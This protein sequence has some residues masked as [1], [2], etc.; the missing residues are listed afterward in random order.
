MSAN[1]RLDRLAKYLGAVLHGR[2]EVENLSDFKRFI[3]AI[4]KQQN[5][6]V[7][8][9]RLVTSPSALSA[10]HN[11]LRFNLTPAFINDYTSKFIKF[12]NNPDVKPLCNGLFLQQLLLVMLEPRSLWNA[13]VYAFHARTLDEDAIQTFCWLVTELLSLPASY[14]VDITGDVQTIVNDDLIVSSP[15]ASLR[16]LGH[17]MKYLLEMKSSASAVLSSEHTAGGRHDNDFSDFR[18]IAI[19]PTADE[20]GCTETPF[21]R[22]VDEISQLSGN[23]RIAA[24][25]DNQFRLLREDMLSG[26]RDDIQVARGTKKG[27]RSALRLQGLSLARISCASADLRYL[28]PC[29]VGVTAKS[30]LNRLE[31]LSKEDKKTYLKQN[32]DFIRHHAFGCFLRDTEIVAFATIERS[33]DDL[34][35]TPPIVMLR[36]AEEEALKKCILFLKIY[37]DVEFL[38]VD[39]PIFA[40][41][42]I[43]KCLQERTDFPLTEELFLYEKDKPVK[44]SSLAPWAVIQELKEKYRRNIEHILQTSRPITLDPSQL[45]SLLKGL[46]QR[47]SLIQGPPGTGKSFIGA[48]LAKVLHDHT[49]DKILVMCYTNHALDQFL[50][51]LLDIGIDASHMV[52]LGSKSTPRTQ[53]LS[54]KEQKITWNRPQTAWNTINLLRSEGDELRNSLNESFTTYQTVVTNPSAI[55]EYLEFEEPAYFEAFTVPD[56][57]D[58]MDVVGKHGNVVNKNYLYQRWV[59][60]QSPEPFNNMLPAQCRSIWEAEKRFRDEKV[61]SWKRALLTEQ[62]ASLAVQIKLFDKCQEKLSGVLG[63]RTREILKR[64]QIIGCTT[65]ASAMY[66][67]DIRNASPGIVLLEEA[68]EILESHVL[69]AISPQTKHLVMI[70]DHLQLRPKVNSYALSLEKGDGYDLNVSLFER[71]IHEGYPHTTLLKQHRMCPEISSLVRSLTYPGLEDDDKT[72]NRPDPR[73]LCD[74]VIFFNHSNVEENFADISDRRDEGAKQ[75][76]RNIFEA[77]IVLKVVKYLGQQGYGTDKL[78]VLTP[79]LGQLLL[80]RQT[81]SKQNDPVLN[82]LDSYDLVQAGLL[83]QASANHSKRPIKLSTIDNYQGEESDIVIASLTRSNEKGDIGFMA[84]AERLNVL[85]SRAR[86]ILIIVGNSKTF[87]SSPKG[88]HTWRPLIDQLKANGHLYDGLPVRCEQHPDKTGILR[89]KEDFETESPDGGCAAP[90]GVKLSCG[91]HECPSRC[92]QLVDHSKM[93]CTKIVKWNCPRGHTLSVPC[94]KIKGACRFCTEEDVIRERKRERDQ[95]LETERQKKQAAYAQ[96]LAELQDEASHLR[97]LRGNVLVDAEQAKVIKQ[98]RDEIEALKSPAKPGRNMAGTQNVAARATTPVSHELIT[99]EKSK[100]YTKPPSDEPRKKIKVPGAMPTQAPS[101]AKSEWDYQKTYHNSQSPEIDQLMDMVGLESVKK[102]F[103]EI[104]QKVDLAIR[105]NIDLSSDRYGTVLLGNPGTGKTTVARLYAK[106]LAAVGIIPGSK[107][108]ETTGSRLANEGVSQCQKTIE[109]LLKHGG[110]VIFIDEAYQLV[111]ANRSGGSQVLD[112]LLAEVENLTGKIVFILAGYQRQMEQFFAHNPGLPSRFPHELK[113]EDFNDTELML[114]LEHWIEKTYKKQMKI[115]GGPGG[116]YCRIVARRIGRGRGSNGFANARAVENVVTKITERQAKRIAR[117][118][119]GSAIVDDFFL[120]KQDMIGPDPSQTLKSSKAWQKLQGLIGL[121]EVKKTVEALVDTIQYNYRRELSEQPLAEYSLNKV[122]LGSPGTGKTSVAKIYGQI[123][124]DIGLLSNGEVIVKNPSDFVGS[125]IG[126]SE[127]NTKGILAATLGKVLV[128]DEAYGLFAGGTSDSTGAK[129]DIFR[130][131]VVDTI[132]AEVQS[133][134]GDD[135]CVLLLGYKDKMQEMFQNVNPGLSRR[136]PIDQAF[137]FEDFTQKELDM[138]L[139]LKLSEQGYEVTDRARSVVLEML[140]RARNR[141]HFGNAGEID[142]LLN[143]AKMHHQRR[144]SVKNSMTLVPDAILDAVD[145]DENYDRVEKSSTSVSKMFEGVIGCENITSKLEGYQQM[146]KNLKKLNMDPRQQVPFNFVFRGP[147]GTGKTSTARK[148]GQVYYD[149]GLLASTEVIEASATDLVGQYIGQTGPKTQHL[150]ERGLGKVLFIDEAYRLA[151]GHF[152]KEAMDEIVDCITKPRFARKLVIILAGYDADINRL[153]SINPGLTSRFPESL[154]FES[155]SPGECIQLLEKLLS[156][157]KR[158]LLE[159]S[160]TKFDISCMQCSDPDLRNK[161]T[162]GFDTL[163]KTASWANARDVETLATAI[164]RKTVTTIEDSSTRGLTL[165]RD[166]VIEE[167]QNMITERHSRE[168][169]QPQHP[170]T[171]VNRSSSFSAPLRTQNTSPPM[172]NI[173]SQNAKSNTV[174]D[175]K[176]NKV[177]PEQNVAGTDQRDDGVADEVWAQLE[178]DKAMADEEEK[179]YLRVT[180]DEQEQKRELQK[181]Q[182]EENRSAR[183]ADEA[184]RREDEEARNRHEQERLR[185]ELERRKKEEIARDLEKKRK[186]LV[187]ARR[188]EQANQAKLRQMGVCVMGYRWIKQSGGYRCAGGSHWVSDAQLH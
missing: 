122:F 135:R 36:I 82:D 58:G 66:S 181:L 96:E 185:H 121:T 117:E 62:A 32:P 70:G 165:K 130:C 147:P 123:L 140:E 21:Y 87:V 71:L 39:S 67:E 75:S 115:D 132:V 162:Q 1:T 155:L 100:E 44:E 42:P 110:G 149:M 4:L 99:T 111:Q 86:N 139:D 93:I 188:K 168:N 25:V 141:P 19:L 156:K 83:S 33:M 173:Q 153:M 108:I 88:R 129:S 148:M 160:Q 35:S 151:E 15:S 84:A 65:T 94:S 78:V 6:A 11:G 182:D 104:K 22:R 107:F 133:T 77:E 73:G 52:R 103:L 163:S 18:K 95:K 91:I 113:F 38:V 105:Q 24:H 72:R 92:H 28:H 76:K 170:L 5:P 89:T 167:I 158:D 31:S 9:E 169:F 17:K 69:T 2:Q 79:Y 49:N 98:Y 85:L 124:V 8:I 56:Y 146:V 150:F 174:S 63:E 166:S 157:Q 172:L 125:V 175:A 137:V 176:I 20:M 34:I 171:K 180:H 29:T 26:L 10:L 131:A 187:E 57:D 120:D 59:R 136:F 23:Q 55:L 51:D 37:D 101:E 13:L 178:K 81:L 109:S 161:L 64:K 53:S 134:P 46:T 184:K 119:K 159:H 116:L 40:Y 61:Q 106:F 3:E 7:T 27:R 145:F 14:A 143:A 74:R 60:G 128:I 48:L 186:A 30:G 50:E 112:F 68:G 164:F 97:R 118:R 90:C 127:K 54:L 80:L 47:L 154:Q 41:E 114:I 144:L 152:A 142:I 102:K 183:E 45:D 138:I 12:L 16:N 179:E 43:L 126:E 177:V